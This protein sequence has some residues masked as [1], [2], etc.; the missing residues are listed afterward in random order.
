MQAWAAPSVTQRPFQSRHVAVR[1]NGA[2]YLGG[3]AGVLAPQADSLPSASQSRVK[4]QL[5]VVRGRGEATSRFAR[6]SGDPLPSG[7]RRFFLWKA[8]VPRQRD[9]ALLAH[10]VAHRISGSHAVCLTLKTLSSPSR[11]LPA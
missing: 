7:E 10:T 8:F 4:R 2:G 9:G 11:K 5:A 1:G 6:A 3:F